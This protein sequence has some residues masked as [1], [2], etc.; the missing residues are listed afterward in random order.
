M[1]AVSHFLEVIIMHFKGKWKQCMEPEVI[2]CVQDMQLQGSQTPQHTPDFVNSKGWF[3]AVSAVVLPS[4]YPEIWRESLGI[5]E[6]TAYHVGE[7]QLKVLG[8]NP[9]I[10]IQPLWEGFC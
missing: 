3:S 2:T 6:S 9:Y 5:L 4:P 10:D 7:K 1:V 8:N